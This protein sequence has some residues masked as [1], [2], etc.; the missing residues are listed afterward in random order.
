MILNPKLFLN[1]AK[2]E[3]KN[4]LYNTKGHNKDL[5]CKNIVDYDLF[6]SVLLKNS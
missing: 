1:T 3:Y 2:L 6:F 5:K 4:F